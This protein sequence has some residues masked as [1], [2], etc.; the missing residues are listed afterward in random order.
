MNRDVYI[1]NYRD[2]SSKLAANSNLETKLRRL[3]KQETNR[4]LK[5]YY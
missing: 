1:S 4:E 3:Y 2:N 5:I